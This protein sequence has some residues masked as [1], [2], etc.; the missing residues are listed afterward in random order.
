MD[1]LSRLRTVPEFAGI[2]HLHHSVEPDLFVAPAKKIQPLT[3]AIFSDITAQCLEQLISSSEGKLKKNLEKLH[4][5]MRPPT[6]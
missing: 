6:L 4:K 2:I 5:R 1:Y 3:T